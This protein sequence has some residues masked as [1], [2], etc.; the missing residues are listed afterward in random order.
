ME[1]CGLIHLKFYSLDES[2]ASVTNSTGKVRYFG[3]LHIEDINWISPNGR[4]L[5]HDDMK[6]RGLNLT[7]GKLTPPLVANCRFTF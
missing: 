6:R 3:V 1:S 2:E 5:I 7:L 4:N